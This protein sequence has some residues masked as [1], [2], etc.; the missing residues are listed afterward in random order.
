MSRILFPLLLLL[1]FAGCVSRAVVRGALSPKEREE[2]V[3]QTGAL[4][5][6]RLKD[7]FVAGKLETGMTK[8]M[9]VFLCGQPD[10]T[11]NERYTISWTAHGDSLP[12]L[13]DSRDSLW[14]YFASDSSTIRTGMLFRGDTLVQMVG[15]KS[16]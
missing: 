5:P 16:K 14:N 6:Q 3:E 9:V 4:I 1:A 12:A 10:R 11:E 13:A 7:S 8:E 2:Y 15:D